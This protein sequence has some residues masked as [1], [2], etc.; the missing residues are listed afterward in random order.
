LVDAV[1]GAGFRVPSTVDLDVLVRFL[2]GVARPI[3]AG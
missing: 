3:A 2:I 1:F